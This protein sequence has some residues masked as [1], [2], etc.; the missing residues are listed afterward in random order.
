M[1]QGLDVD[2]EFNSI[3]SFRG[4]SDRQSGELSVF[5][6]AGV[7]LVHGWLADPAKGEEFEALQRAGSY[8]GAQLVMVR[9]MEAGTKGLSVDGTTAFDLSDEDQELVD[10]CKSLLFDRQIGVRAC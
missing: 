1:T 2:I 10:D 5:Q 8:E 7:D 9:G 3:S 6:Y 4:I